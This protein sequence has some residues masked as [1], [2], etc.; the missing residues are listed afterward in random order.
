MRRSASNE[1]QA[2][3]TSDM[4]RLRQLEQENSLLRILYADLLQKFSSMKDGLVR[5]ARLC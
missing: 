4:K 3:K 5:H 2:M 1:S